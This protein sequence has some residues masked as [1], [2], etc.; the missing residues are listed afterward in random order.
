MH[1][2]YDYPMPNQS[3][4][5]RI[6]EPDLRPPFTGWIKVTV[7][8]A[9][10][11]LLQEQNLQTEEVMHDLRQ[12]YELSP[13]DDAILCAEIKAGRACGPIHAVLK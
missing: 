8:G 12:S 1:R 3:C 11:F 9:N 7:T 13:A 5:I 4:E 10:G 2:K 6:G